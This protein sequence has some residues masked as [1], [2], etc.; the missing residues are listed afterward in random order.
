MILITECLNTD[1]MEPCNNLLQLAVVMASCLA[2][3]GQ[4]DNSG[5]VPYA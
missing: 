5:Y 4:Y 1:I 3:T 2:L